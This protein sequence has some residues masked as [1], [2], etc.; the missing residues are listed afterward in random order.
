MSSNTGEN[1]PVIV[2]KYGGSSVSDAAR[3]SAIAR[4]ISDRS[5]TGVSLVIV[6]SAMGDSTDR[7]I[8][9]AR[10]VSGDQPP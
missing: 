3:I 6:V 7:L 2:Q 4:K 5:E 1:R 10:N 8:E 9:M